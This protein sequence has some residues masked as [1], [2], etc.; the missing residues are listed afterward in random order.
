VAGGLG[1]VL[2]HD[3]DGE[4]QSVAATA[5]LAA[6][7]GGPT[8]VEGTAEL[9]DSADGKQLSVTTVGLP[10]RS[11]YY[12]VWLYNPGLNQMVAV[13]TLASDHAGTFPVPPG[14]D[15]ADYSV[16]DVSAQKFDG[17]P[18]HQLSV[19]RGELSP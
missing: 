19:L 8:Q 10:S 9:L 11:G 13:G 12:E 4:Q 16:V 14:L 17:N 2:G 5:T 3:S 18:E 6:M 7:P 15:P 1:Y